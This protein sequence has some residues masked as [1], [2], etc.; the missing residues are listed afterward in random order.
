MANRRMFSK[1]ITDTDVFLDMPLSTQALYFHLNMHADD[2]GFVSNSKTIKRMVGASDDDLKLL[3]AKQF[4][5]TF[6]SGVVVIKDWKIHNY[7]R[8]DTYNSTICTDEKKQLTTDE[9]GSYEFRGRTVDEPSPQVR[10]GKVRLG[11]DSI[12]KQQLEQPL[13]PLSKYDKYFSAISQFCEKNFGFVAPI[14]QESLQYDFEDWIKLNQD[15]KQVTNIICLALKEAAGANKVSNK[16]KYAESILD[17]WEKNKLTTVDE[18]K[19]DQKEH[20]Q[21]QEQRQS[22]YR[23]RQPVQKEKV[24]DWSEATNQQQQYTPEQQEKLKAKL[25]ALSGKKEVKS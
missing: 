2:D 14:W 18:I 8:K 25:A 10:L 5:F 3:I 19:A 17:R 12:E 15:P 20:Q 7:I 1:K 22:G 16:V 21:R 13:L 23:Q 4:I 6:D 24:P 9:K 11:K